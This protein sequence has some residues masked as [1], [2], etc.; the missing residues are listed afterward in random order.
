MKPPR[1]LSSALGRK[2]YPGSGPIFELTNQKEACFKIAGPL[3]GFPVTCKAPFSQLKK[4]LRER[5]AW[6]QALPCQPRS[7]TLT[8]VF[9][10]RPEPSEGKAVLNEMNRPALAYRRMCCFYFL[11]KGGGVEGRK[12]EDCMHICVLLE[13]CLIA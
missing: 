4:L 9:P 1:N 11:K 7:E 10:H 13:K 8:F 6:S 2:L 3:I 5:K 12:K